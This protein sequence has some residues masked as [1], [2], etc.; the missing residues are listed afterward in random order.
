MR[1][2]VPN[3]EKV[4][5]ARRSID[6]DMTESP[7]GLSDLRLLHEALQYRARRV[8]EPGESVRLVGLLDRVEEL[9][10]D[11]GNEPRSLRLSPPEQEVLVRQ[12]L[13]YCAELTGRG[14][15]QLGRTQALELK[16][17]VERVSPG[18]LRKKPWWRFW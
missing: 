4:Q 13:A 7:L 6:R 12:V 3:G 5:P 14:A 8:R 1:E 15:S 9:L 10:L 11:R 2:Y 17:L 18:R 16:G